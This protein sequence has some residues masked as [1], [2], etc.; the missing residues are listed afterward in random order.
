MKPDLRAMAQHPAAFRAG[1]RIDSDRGPIPL[2]T[3]AD[4]WQVADF[5][6]LDDAWRLVAGH[7]VQPAALRA[8]LERPRGH[9]KTSDLAVMATWALAFSRRRLAGV[10]AAADREQARLLRDAIA[11]LVSVNPWLSGTLDVQAYRIINKRNE[12][13]LE[14]LSSDAATSYGLTPDFV[15]V[16][17]LTHWTS[18]ELWDSLISAAAKRA[19]CLVL[20]ISNAGWGDT[21][22]WAAREAIRTDPRWYFSRLDGPKASW[23]TAD[24]LDEQQ[25]LLPRIA[26]ERLWLN[27][28]TSGSG[29][30]LDEEVLR[31]AL[32]MLAP[33]IEPSQ[34][35]TYFAG[36]DLSTR[37]DATGL[38]ILGRDDG[39]DEQLPRQK[40]RLPTTVAALADLGLI[41]HHEPEPEVIHH[42]GNGRLRLVHVALWEPNGQRIDLTVVEKA[43]VEAHEHWGLSAMCADAWQ[44]ELL[45]QRLAA[46]G[47]PIQPVQG[48]ATV[49][50]ETATALLNAFRARNID[51]YPHA[52][53]LADLGNLRVVER[54]G[55]AAGFRLVSPRGNET[56]T[57]HG[58]LASALQLALLAANR[59]RMIGQHVQGPLVCYP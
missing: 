29:D 26:Y 12:S 27:R 32:T 20:C 22:Q 19:H 8:Y 33:P 30:A 24:R 35:E 14:I 37:Q 42:E 31:A 25:R 44:A 52:E 48:T 39:W 50:Q 1:L 53:L 3:I 16:D 15:I 57:R 56:G 45:C 6:A 49:A 28:W 13:T 7:A 17:E 38:I 21:W 54:T 46:Q 43:I 4:P 23:I 55:I 2:A 47:V 41:E 18:R 11:R 51:L 59:G 34:G 10:A 36:L 58:D 40:R 9:S 5:E